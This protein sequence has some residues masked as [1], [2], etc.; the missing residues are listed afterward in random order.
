MLQFFR[1]FIYPAVAGEFVVLRFARRDPLL[2]PSFSSR[3]R[4]RDVPSFANRFSDDPE[5]FPSL[6]LIG[7]NARII[8]KVNLRRWTRMEAARTCFPLG[9]EN[10]V[11]LRTTQ[12]LT[13]ITRHVTKFGGRVRR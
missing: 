7:R 3:I 1:V 2:L 11:D 12:L 4:S 6:A 8:I 9:R 10:D 13:S 5:N